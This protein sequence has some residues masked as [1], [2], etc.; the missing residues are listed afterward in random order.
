MCYLAAFIYLI[1]ITHI[2]RSNW[3]G[4]VGYLELDHIFQ[5]IACILG[6]GL[7]LVL[8]FFINLGFV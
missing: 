4:M 7:S 5:D 6:L 3:K 8:G 1:K 2:G